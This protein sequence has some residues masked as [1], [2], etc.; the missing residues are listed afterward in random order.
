MGTKGKWYL[1]LNQAAASRLF[2][3]GDG[4]TSEPKEAMFFN[5]LTEA[6]NEAHFRAN[7]STK[8]EVVVDQATK[9]I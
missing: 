1:W 2:W 7:R 9:N 5:T 6:N 3:A 4:W 8:S